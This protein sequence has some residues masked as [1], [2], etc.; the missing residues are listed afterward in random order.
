[1]DDSCFTEEGYI[2]KKKGYIHK[3]KRYKYKKKGYMYK[4]RS[5]AALWRILKYTCFC[6]RAAYVVIVDMI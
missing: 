3:K 1:M 4:K 5:Y 6:P 2:Y